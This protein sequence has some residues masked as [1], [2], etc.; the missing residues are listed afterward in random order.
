MYADQTEK[1]AIFSHPAGRWE[2]KEI[3]DFLLEPH[4]RTARLS[5]KEEQQP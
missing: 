1:R 3:A 2:A 5:G 4:R